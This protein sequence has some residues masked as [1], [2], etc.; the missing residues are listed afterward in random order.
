MEDEQY[1]TFEE[2]LDSGEFFDGMDAD[3]IEDWYE[4]DN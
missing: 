4:K 1:Q 2:Y 3:E